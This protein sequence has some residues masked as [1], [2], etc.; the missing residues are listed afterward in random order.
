VDADGRETLDPARVAALLP[1]G[2]HKGYGLSLLDELLAALIGG[3]LPTL[4]SRPQ[5]APPGE[6]T[7]PCFFFQVIHPRAIEC[8]AFAAGRSQTENVRAVV[9][10]ILGHGNE[11]CLL[12]GQLEHQAA[13]RSARAKG[14]IFTDAEVAG[15]S[16]IAAEA[17]VSF[18][19]ATLCPAA[20]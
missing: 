2:A 12:P 11:R 14:L 7:T 8:G 6:K 10:D 15:L 19:P 9:Q 4:R 20:P 3:S 18:D 16:R 17:G 1:F 13:L 5:S